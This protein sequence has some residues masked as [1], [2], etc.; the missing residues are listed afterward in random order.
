LRSVFVWIGSMSAFLFVV[1]PI[2]R[3]IVIRVLLGK[4]PLPVLLLVYLA[5]C[6]ALAFPYRWF[7]QKFLSFCEKRT[8]ASLAS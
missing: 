5:L 1:H 2:A 4:V 3:G 6:F 8:P 7:F